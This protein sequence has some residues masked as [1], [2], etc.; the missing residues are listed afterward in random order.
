MT[1]SMLRQTV[2]NAVDSYPELAAATPGTQTGDDGLDKTDTNP[3]GQSGPRQAGLIVNFQSSKRRILQ[4]EFFTNSPDPVTLEIHWLDN[5]FRE[6]IADGQQIC[7]QS[8]TVDLD[9]M[10]TNPKDLVRQRI[11]QVCGS[12]YSGRGRLNVPEKLR[13]KSHHVMIRIFPAVSTTNVY[14]AKDSIYVVR[15]PKHRFGLGKEQISTYAL[16]PTQE[17][18]DQRIKDLVNYYGAADNTDDSANIVRHWIYNQIYGG[19]DTPLLTND[20]DRE[21]P[22]LVRMFSAAKKNA[23]RENER[24]RNSHHGLANDRRVVLEE[25][26]DNVPSADD[27]VEISDPF[28]RLRQW[29]IIIGHVREVTP[30]EDAFQLVWRHLY[31]EEKI[32]PL[33][34]ELTI[35]YSTARSIICRAKKHLGI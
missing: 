25:F 12:Q 3:C 17:Q 23:I 13:R 26:P 19:Y 18:A 1:T 11:L 30:S 24:Q 9:L 35:N 33:A 14:A 31:E 16:L 7:R 34:Q 27:V 2:S 6:V 28:E 32:K 15:R 5:D 10:V 22:V 21:D 20:V 29:N 4:L 8:C